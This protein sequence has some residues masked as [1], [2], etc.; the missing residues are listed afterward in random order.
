VL[1]IDG[2]PPA[3][4]SL[5]DTVNVPATARVRIA[6]MPDDRPGAWMAH[7]HILEHHAAGMMTHFHVIR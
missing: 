1:S 4:R 6:W 7:C 2:F 3:Y 5:E